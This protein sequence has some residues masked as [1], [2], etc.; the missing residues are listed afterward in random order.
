G[1]GLRHIPGRPLS[2]RGPGGVLLRG[3]RRAAPAPQF[4]IPPLDGR[5]G[6][7]VAVAL[8]AWRGRPGRGPVG[9][10]RA[11]PGP[12]G[13]L[14]LLRGLSLPCARLRQP[15][16]RPLLVGMGSLAV[17]ARPRPTCSARRGSDRL[18]ACRLAARPLAGGRLGR[19]D[20]L[21]P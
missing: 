6:G 17:P 11:R 18:P 5:R 15:V 9:A 3:E 12:P 13:G 21:P 7:L 14:P 16:R 19:R 8:P 10:A 1:G 4:H 2:R 20:R